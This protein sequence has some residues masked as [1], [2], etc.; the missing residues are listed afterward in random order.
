VRIEAFDPRTAD[1]ATA[2]AYCSVLQEAAADSWPAGLTPPPEHLLNR[3][4][5]MNADQRNFIWLAYDGDEAFA[6]AEV[7]WWEAPDN[8]DRG[9]LYVEVTPE[10]WSPELVAA[11]VPAVA[12]TMRAH[13]RTLLNVEVPRGHPM[14]GWLEAHGGRRGSVEEHNVW[15]S[16]GADAGDLRALSAVPDG[17]ELVAFDGA[18]PEELLEA[19]TRLADTMNTAPR[20]DLTMEDWVYTPQRVRNWEQGIERRGH[21]IWTIVAREVATGELAAFNQLVVRPEWPECIE[22]EDTAVAVAHR[23]HGLGL[24]IKATN[25]L[26]VVTERPEAQAVETWNAASNTHMLRVNRRLG[27]VAE[28]VW[29]SWEIGLSEAE[30][31]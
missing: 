20:D 19:Y 3:V 6:V 29:E 10:R 13:G 4:R 2:L 1:E 27:F 26:R 22:N 23:G 8:R 15:R 11:F 28:H 9:W 14:N 12:E 17:Y 18:C 30:T 31:A 24:C 5:N 21:T 16:A 25:L 7:S